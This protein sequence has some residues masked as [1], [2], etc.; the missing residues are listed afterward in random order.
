MSTGIEA[1]EAA[2]QEFVKVK[3]PKPSSAFAVFSIHK[4]KSIECDFVSEIA[5]TDENYEEAVWAK[6]IEHVSE[7]LKKK[8]AYIVV[9]FHC[10]DNG[11]A[12]SKLILINWIPENDISAME[13]M[14]HAGSLEALKSYFSG[15][16]PVQATELA[17]LD[18]SLVVEQAL[19][20]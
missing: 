9:D 12:T 18:Y 17:E 11:R 19:K 14:P 3:G 20:K 7:N 16:K 5:P 2:F 10:V 8:A 15:S 13:K 4:R 1:S 6:V